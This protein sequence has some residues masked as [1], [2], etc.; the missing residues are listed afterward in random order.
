MR[1]SKRTSL[2]LIALVASVVLSSAA[3]A[4]EEDLA[5]KASGDKNDKSGTNPINFQD[6]IRFYSEYSWLN[7]EGD[8]NQNLATVEYRTPFAGGKWQYRMRLNHKSFSIDDDDDGIDEINSTGIGDFDFRFL[9][10]F[11]LKGKNGYAGAMEVF[12]NSANKEELGGGT[13]TLAPQVFYARFFTGGFGPWRGGL[14]APGLQWR[15]SVEEDPG[16]V[17]NRTIAIDLNL[18]MMG[19]SKKHWV[20]AN[21]QILRNTET[22][23]ESAVIDIEFG[24]MLKWKGQ[25]AYIRP[26]IGVGT[27]RPADFGLEFGYKFVGFGS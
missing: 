15:H 24:R 18:L 14:F 10:I 11:A 3:F 27:D 22:N 9:T 12:L 1:T 2:I 25:S 19:K 13:T 17:K 7:T 20:Y 4:E 5:A 26:A 16:R 6:D 21:P 8:G 23:M